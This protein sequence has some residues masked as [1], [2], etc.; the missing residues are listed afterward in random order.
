MASGGESTAGQARTRTCELWLEDGLLRGRFLPDA[1][2]SGDDARENLDASVRLLG[3]KPSPTLID[4]RSV[5][6]QSAEARTV[7][8][9][10]GALRVSSKVALLVGSPLSRVVGSFFLRFNRPETTTRLFD[11]EGKALAWLR[12]E[13]GDAR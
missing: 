8:A 2:V 13:A 9:G 6:S 5:R 7:L 3:G 4:L 10:P 11:D 12:S 1:D